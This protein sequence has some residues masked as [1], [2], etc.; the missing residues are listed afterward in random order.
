M[1]LALSASLSV[2]EVSPVKK[3][4]LPQ[5]PLIPPKAKKS[6]AKTTLQVRD[7]TERA[8]QITEAVSQILMSEIDFVKDEFC[9]KKS[10]N[11]GK[12]WNLASLSRDKEEFYIDMIKS[13]K[14][15][16]RPKG[17]ISLSQ[18]NDLKLFE[19]LELCQMT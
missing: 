14:S 11:A 8:K 1:A 7:S 2:S 13:Y 12:F 15:T 9:M 5:A 6:K 16:P 10:E 4:W 3:C 17:M 18:N 19:G